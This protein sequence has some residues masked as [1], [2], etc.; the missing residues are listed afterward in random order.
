MLTASHNPGEYNGFKVKRKEGCSV[1][2]DEAKWIEEE[3]NN[4][5]DQEGPQRWA[6]AVEHVR[7]QSYDDYVARLLSLVDVEAIRKAGLKVVADM[8]HGAGG[9]YFDGALRQAGCEVL[10]LRANP[11]PT[12]EGHHPEPLGPNLVESTRLTA[13]PS[14]DMGL[15]TD[16]DADRFGLMT[17]GHFIDVQRTIVYV[18]YHL[19]KNRGAK[20]RV[21][22]AVNVTSMLDELCRHFGVAVVET[23][24]GFKNIA[25]EMIETNDIILAV[26]ESGGFGIHGHIPD[27]DGTFTALVTCEARATEGKPVL[28]TLD[29]I[30]RIVGGLRAF[31]RL[32]LPITEEQRARIKAA[33]PEHEPDT[34]AG[35]KVAEVNRLDGE[36][37]IRDDGTWVM[38]RPS[39]TEPLIRIYAEGMN[40]QDVQ[41]LLEAGRQ[42]VQQIGEG[43]SMGPTGSLHVVVLAGGVGTR[44]WPVSRRSQP[45]QFQALLS[46]RTMLEE[47]YARVLPLTSPDRACGWSP[48]R[49]PWNWFA[50]SFR[51]YRARMSSANPSAA[52][53]R[54]P[55]RLAV[56]RIVRVDPDATVL[57]TPADSYIVDAAAYRDYIST[58]I[59]AAA[60]GAI[61]V[62][63][64]I[65]T[66]P[67]TNY[68]YIKRGARLDKPTAAYR[69][70]RFTEK[71]NAYTAAQYVADGGYYWNMGQYVFR[72]D[73]FMEK[74]EQYL[75]EVASRVRQLA[76]KSPT[77]ESFASLYQD[78]PSIS[79]DYGI[80][81]K[82]PNLAVVPTAVEWSDLGN[83]QAVKDISVRHGVPPSPNHIAID[84]EDC[85]V[86]ARSGRL[87]V[88][89]GLQGYVIVDTPDALLVV[90]EDESAKVREALD[91][92]VKRGKEEHL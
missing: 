5:L 83:W 78:M 76:E 7:F 39:G 35:R 68:G 37:F 2:E 41:G 61:V 72:A 36:K 42:I 49:N 4:I 58:A 63:G 16:G 64:I 38:L 88:T 77:A 59:E 23:S 48:A 69:V 73:V 34:L 22:R 20:G 91:E 71:P 84:S 51:T 27:R 57:M 44:L 40:D 74:C 46:E 54:P 31:D 52:I 90:R 15:A 86:M 13:D 18:L 92:I 3:A 30:G 87:V 85:Y 10:S 60:T 24:V 43:N 29:E 53:A 26:E 19:L 62:L 45:K 50:R 12:F 14:V 89:I 67:N 28:E 6:P 56:A 66:A 25:P 55:P 21:V 32:D 33:L 79:L 75:P 9:G 47:T 65:P 11:D 80:A 70:E 81:E 1:M 8:M 82:E 17:A